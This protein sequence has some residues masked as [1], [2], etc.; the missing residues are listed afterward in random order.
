MK[1]Q[2]QNQKEL[3]DVVSI[4][5][6]MTQNNLTLKEFAQKAGI[7]FYIAKKIIKNQPI[8]SYRP[9]VAICKL[10]KISVDHFM[11]LDKEPDYAP[12]K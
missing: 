3:Y 10:I 7:S 2:S 8:K 1:N 11:L 12:R 4:K 6:Y 5:N 9:A